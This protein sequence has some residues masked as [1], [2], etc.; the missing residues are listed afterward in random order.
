MPKFA[1][2][3]LEKYYR[4]YKQEQMAYTGAFLSQIRQQYQSR[5]EKEL[6]L[7]PEPEQKIEIYD[8]IYEYIV[9]IIIITIK[10]T[11]NYDR[12]IFYLIIYC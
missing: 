5:L 6:E 9:S 3:V 12:L 7:Y 10:S 8:S 1:S 2:K 11:N 4:R